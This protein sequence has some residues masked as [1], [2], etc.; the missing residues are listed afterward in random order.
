MPKSCLCLWFNQ[1]LS[2][3][4][5]E[6]FNFLFCFIWLVILRL[7]Q[8]ELASAFYETYLEAIFFCL[9]PQIHADR[10]QTFIKR[11]RI[12]SCT[13]LLVLKGWSFIHL[14]SDINTCVQEHITSKMYRQWLH[15]KIQN[16]P[17]DGNVDCHLNCCN[18]DG[19][20]I[21]GIPCFVMIQIVNNFFIRRNFP[22]SWLV[23]H[24]LLPIFSFLR[25][26]RLQQ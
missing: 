8:L 9:L 19:Y 13:L 3:A 10:S 15:Q 4:I 12:I 24:I 1:L 7:N 16:V 22:L 11:V 23:S 14:K 20:I 2:C 26:M 17:I 6:V 5:L 18:R 21:V 25:L